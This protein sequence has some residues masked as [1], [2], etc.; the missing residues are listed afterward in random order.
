[1]CTNQTSPGT[2]ETA[3]LTTGG[4]VRS[5]R[6][7]VCP[8]L[9]GRGAFVRLDCLG[10]YL[11][12]HARHR[13]DSKVGSGQP[14][15]RPFH[16]RVAS[17]RLLLRRAFRRLGCCCCCC[18]ASA[19]AAAPSRVLAR[20]VGAERR[21]AGMAAWKLCRKCSAGAP[22]AAAYRIDSTSKVAGRRFEFGSTAVGC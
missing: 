11:G 6:T 7:T 17:S 8:H 15:A 19:G 21:W 12:R 14:R 4:C 3:V 22:V 5:I 10:H 9:R 16:R 2:N 20:V 13:Q 18:S 1:M